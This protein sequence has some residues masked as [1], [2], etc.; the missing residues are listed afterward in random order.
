LFVK[1][2]GINGQ[3]TGPFSTPAGF[4]YTPVQVTDAISDTTQ[5]SN[6]GTGSLLTALA[7]TQLLKYVDNLFS[8]NTVLSQGAGGV[9]DTMFKTFKGNTGYDIAGNAGNIKTLTNNIKNVMI[10]AASGSQNTTGLTQQASNSAPSS[11]MGTTVT[12]TPPVSGTYKLDVLV[13]Q[14]YSGAEGGRGRSYA[15]V[16][17]LNNASP[18]GITNSGVVAGAAFDPSVAGQTTELYLFEKEDIINVGFSLR[19]SANSATVCTATSG[20]VGATGWMDFALTNTAVLSSSISYDL[21]FAYF[22]YT[23]S[24][25]SATAGF[26]IGYNVYTIS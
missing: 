11:F 1:T 25:P 16:N 24:N 18:V 12:F 14:N 2:R 8:A 19:Y 22:A 13:D 7:L 6:T 10:S 23:R 17:N 20:G 4:V 21:K 15:I 5:V 9:F 3:T 26:D